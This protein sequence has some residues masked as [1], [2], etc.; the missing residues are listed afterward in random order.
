[1][2]VL[3]RVLVFGVVAA[4]HVAALLADAQVHPSVAQRHALGADVV[5]VALEVVQVEGGEM[6]AG[7][8]HGKEEK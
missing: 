8:V 5:R 1:V 6:L 2:E 3:G 4:A 7:S